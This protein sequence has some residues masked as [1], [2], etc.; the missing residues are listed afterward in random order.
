MEVSKQ[1]YNIKSIQDDQ[2]IGAPVP[3][4]PAPTP[5]PSPGQAS[6]P[7]MQMFPS[8]SDPSLE[9]TQLESLWAL[10]AEASLA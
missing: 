5:L 4:V 8:S 2:P 10:P 9:R 7:S 6:I 3:G 1:S